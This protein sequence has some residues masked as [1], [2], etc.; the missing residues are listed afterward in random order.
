MALGRL[1]RDCGAQYVQWMSGC[2]GLV[3][4]RYLCGGRGLGL[5]HGNRL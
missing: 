4:S 5:T 1:G 2:V 3:G